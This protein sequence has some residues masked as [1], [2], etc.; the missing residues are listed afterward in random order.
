MADLFSLNF[1]ITSRSPLYSN[2]NLDRFEG[3]FGHGR[4]LELDWYES[5]HVDRGCTNHISATGKVYSNYLE[6]LAFEQAFRKLIF[7]NIDLRN[8]FWVVAQPTLR[9]IEKKTRKLFFPIP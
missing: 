1:F 4:L 7:W 2:G 6:Q 3:E 9:L 8:E 5:D